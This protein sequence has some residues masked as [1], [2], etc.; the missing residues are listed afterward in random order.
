[1][2]IAIGCDHAAVELKEALLS[3][4]AGKGHEVLD[5]GTRGAESVDYPDFG[6]KVARAVAGGE[7]DRGI[8]ICGTG[9]GMSIV[10]N[11]VPGIRAALCSEPFS[12]RMSR[13]HNDANVLVLGGRVTGRN[14]AEEIVATWL[15]TPF[16][17]GRHARRL[18]KI[19][20]IEERH[21]EQ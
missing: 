17:G 2:K 6:E 1:M 18:E 16:E 3:L 20:A 9:I 19:T 11:K 7:S 10:A 15:D 21:K 5:L 4:L 12:A 8:L 13:L 14:L